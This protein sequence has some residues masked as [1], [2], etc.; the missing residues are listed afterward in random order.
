MQRMVRSLVQGA[1]PARTTRVKREGRLPSGRRAAGRAQ[2]VHSS[3]GERLRP[4]AQAP[5]HPCLPALALAALLLLS[6]I[7]CLSETPGF[8]GAAGSSGAG[9]GCTLLACFRLQNASTQSQRRRRLSQQ[10][11][12]SS[13]AAALHAVCAGT[14]RDAAGPSRAVIR[15][16][17]ALRLLSVFRIQDAT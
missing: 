11:S 16:F 7:S 12:S 17:R 1:C 14:C 5:V 8:A 10:C 13:G 9:A 6:F 3:N 4:G 2:A 15:P